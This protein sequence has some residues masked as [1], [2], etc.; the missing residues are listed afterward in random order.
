MS[1]FDFSDFAALNARNKARQQAAKE[2]QEQ[3]QELERQTAAINKNGEIFYT[4]GNYIYTFNES[5][6]LKK[7][8]WRK[9]GFFGNS[10]NIF[11]TFVLNDEQLLLESLYRYNLSSY[12]ISNKKVNNIFTQNQSS[13]RSLNGAQKNTKLSTVSTK[14]G[15]I[16]Y[17]DYLGKYSTDFSTVINTNKGYRKNLI[18][19]AFG[20]V[21]STNGNLYIISENKIYKISL[22]VK[23]YEINNWSMHRGNIYR[24]ASSQILNY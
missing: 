8:K 23:G 6:Y 7:T 12:N 20:S 15:V 17:F 4:L 24:T 1:D 14:D 5:K 10:D 11:N 19:N 3:L 16:I 9:S 13:F 21:L 18:E 22:D 2:H